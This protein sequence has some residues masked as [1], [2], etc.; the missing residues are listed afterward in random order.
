MINQLIKENR[1]L[2]RR[3]DKLT[4]RATGAT[5]RTVERALVAMQRRVQKAIGSDT[6]TTTRR[7]T[8]TT[9]RVRR[10]VSPE[11]AEKRR[12][13]LEKARAVR[14]AKREAASATE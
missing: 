4:A 6:G 13:A 3:V 11:V 10:P 2:R 5:S 8:T 7:R 14:A 1:Q 12:A 9:A